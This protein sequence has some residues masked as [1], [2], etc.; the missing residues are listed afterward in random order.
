MKTGQLIKAT[1]VAVMAVW[2]VLTAQ[3]NAGESTDDVDYSTSHTNRHLG[4]AW[5]GP[6]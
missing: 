6:C 5:S 3:V 2:M 4:Y 1:L